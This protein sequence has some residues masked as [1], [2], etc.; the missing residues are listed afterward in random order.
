[1]KLT[2]SQLRQIIEEEV[3]KAALHEDRDRTY[4]TAKQLKLNDMLKLTERLDIIVADMI[5]SEEKEA[6]MGAGDTGEI[7][8]LL[9]LQGMI[10]ELDLTVSMTLKGVKVLADAAAQAGKIRMP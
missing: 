3:K 5:E 6:G 8:K 4:Y 9:D 1:M 10:E 7:D 2:T